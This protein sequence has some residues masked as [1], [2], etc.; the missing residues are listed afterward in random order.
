MS[1]IERFRHT[2]DGKLMGTPD[3][4]WVSYA[5]H[6]AAIDRAEEARDDAQALVSC[7]CGHD[8]STDICLGHIVILNRVWR[9]TSPLHGPPGDAVARTEAEKA[10]AVEAMRDVVLAFDKVD[11]ML[12]D[13]GEFTAAA[14]LAL[15]AKIDAIRA[16]AKRL[17]E[18]G[19]G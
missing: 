17:R 9:I 7:A 1:D 2:R 3:G 6:Q 14:W 18:G 5:D 10:A 16:K 15:S 19:E 12:Q 11:A 4:D 13:A 8:N